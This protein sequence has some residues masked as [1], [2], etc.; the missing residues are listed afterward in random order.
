MKSLWSLVAKPRRGG[1]DILRGVLKWL[2]KGALL[3]MLRSEMSKTHMSSIHLPPEVLLSCCWE[4]CRESAA[5]IFSALLSKW[6]WKYSIHIAAGYTAA[7]IDHLAKCKHFKLFRLRFFRWLNH[8]SV[9][10]VLPV[11]F[12]SNVCVVLKTKCKILLDQRWHLMKW[13]MLQ[14]LTHWMCK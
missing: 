14:C 12:C 3:S 10:N 7:Y 13:S 6:R 2:D 1:K 5:F 9:V 11:V 8:D 4:C